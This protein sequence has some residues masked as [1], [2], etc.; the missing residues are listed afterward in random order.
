MSLLHRIKREEA[1]QHR[2]KLMEAYDY[3]LLNVGIS[4]GSAP[5]WWDYINFIKGRRGSTKKRGGR[6]SSH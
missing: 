3:V 5:V 1:E 4:S 2:S 6:K